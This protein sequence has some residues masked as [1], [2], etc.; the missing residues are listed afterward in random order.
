[1]NFTYYEDLVLSFKAQKILPLKLK[2]Y[3]KNT[4]N[5]LSA[6]MTGLILV[7][8]GNVNAGLSKLQEF[9]YLEPDLIITGGVKNYIERRIKTGR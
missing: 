6:V 9:C 7:E 3:S 8:Q 2:E 5:P 4:K 1:M